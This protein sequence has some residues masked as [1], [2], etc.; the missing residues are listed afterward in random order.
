LLTTAFRFHKEEL[1]GEEGNYIH[2]RAYVED[3]TPMEVLNDIGRELLEARASIYAVLAKSPRAAE[4]W[5][6][7]ERGCMCVFFENPSNHI[8]HIIYSVWHLS[9]DRYQLKDLDL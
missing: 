3:S 6:N 9:Q 1:T 2:N 4:T 5:Q 7:F 8:I